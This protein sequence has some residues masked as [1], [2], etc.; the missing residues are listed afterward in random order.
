MRGMKLIT[1]TMVRIDLH[2]HHATRAMSASGAYEMPHLPKS[3]VKSRV[4]QVD[5]GTSYLL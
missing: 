2:I 5:K 4:G 1:A 3:M